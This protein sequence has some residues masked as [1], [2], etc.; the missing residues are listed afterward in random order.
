MRHRMTV[1]AIFFL[2]SVKP[3][4]FVGSQALHFFEPMVNAFF[5]MRDYERF[6][7]LMERR[8][9]L[10]VL[11]VKIEARDDAARQEERAVRERERAERAARKR[12][13]DSS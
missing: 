11:L 1:P 6:A 9:N 4:S 10:E 5:Q 12:G 2:E 7:I 8:E 13:K 3:L